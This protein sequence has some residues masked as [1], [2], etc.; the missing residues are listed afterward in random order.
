[1]KTFLF[2]AGGI[3]L[4]AVLYITIAG[5]IYNNSIIDESK[6]LFSDADTSSGEIITEADLAGLPGPVQRYLRFA[7]VVGKKRVK[8][9]RLKQTGRIKLSPGQD[10]TDIK[11]TQYY[12]VDPPGLI[13]KGE[14]AS[15]PVSIMAKDSFVNGKGHMLI[16][17]LS[18]FT[19]GD[20][21]G[22]AMDQGAGMR[23]LNEIM[24]F[25]TAYL[26]DYISWQA[27]DDTSARV[28]AEFGGQTLSAVCEFDKEGR[29]TAFK[30]PRYRSTE[31]GPVLTEWITPIGDYKEINGIMI[32]TTG[33]AVWVLED[34]EFE[35]IRLEIQEIEYDIP[36]V[37]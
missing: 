20:E 1:M 17:L 7:K 14:A 19:V 13:W 4:G 32:P 6:K 21:L 11:G 28:T 29:M 10:W 25:P 12:S 3:I 35:Y 22:P 36:E 2:I 37:Y 15:G 24:W 23:F 30:A 26:S 8:T 18:V 34:G 27:I 31:N 9:V 33:K 5:V 16:K